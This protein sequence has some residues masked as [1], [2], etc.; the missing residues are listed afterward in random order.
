MKQGFD[1]VGFSI[2]PLLIL[3]LLSWGITGCQKNSVSEQKTELKDSVVVTP[4]TS[5]LK[6]VTVAVNSGVGGYYL[7]LPSNYNQTTQKY[8]LL[9][10]IPGAGQFGD[11][12]FDLPLLLRM[13]RRSWWMRND[14]RARLQ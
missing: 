8:P 9:V 2:R 12:A 7:A 11:G 6:P 14:S 5:V 10:F 4:I 13:A 3:F 1:T